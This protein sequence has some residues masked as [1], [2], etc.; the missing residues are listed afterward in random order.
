MNTGSR[1]GGAAQALRWCDAEIVLI[2]RRN[3]H[4]FQSL[5]YQV[6]TAIVAPSE[7]AAPPRQLVGRQP[8]LFVILAEDTVWT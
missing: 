2:D 7:V 3:H 5:L 6:A 8:N 4:I 1:R